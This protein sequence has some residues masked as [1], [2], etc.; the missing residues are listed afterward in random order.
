VL[1]QANPGRLRPLTAILM[2]LACASLLACAGAPKQPELDPAKVQQFQ[3]RG[4]PARHQYEVTEASDLR[5]VH[6]QVMRLVWLRPQVP[7]PHPLVVYMPGAGQDA[8]A[9]A[10]WRQALAEA[11]YVVLSWQPLPDD[12]RL[13]YTP[14]EQRGDLKPWASQRFASDLMQ[15]RAQLLGQLMAEL[16]KA[17]ASGDVLLKGV[18]LAHVA[19]AG[20]ELG[21]Y[22]TMLMAGEQLPGVNDV[23]QVSFQAYVVIS[24]FA[25]FEQG[26]F[27]TRY[28]DVKGPMLTITSEAD[29]DPFKMVAA[30]YLRTAPFGGMPA[31]DKVMLMMHQ[32]DHGSLGGREGLDAIMADEGEGPPGGAGP[33]KGS[34]GRSGGGSPGGGMPSGGGPGGGMGGGQGGPGGGPGGDSGAGGG[35]KAGAGVSPTMRAMQQVALGVSSVAFLDAYL[36]AD[37]LARNWMGAQAIKW[38]TP[39]ADWLNK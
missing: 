18:D 14:G 39:V 19:L 36:Q 28:K 35:M 38:L 33:G 2:A 22:T 32:A 37:P 23:P 7:G 20:Y 15:R 25:S 10:S 34:G 6:G 11:G 8:K 1:R 24:P 26:R 3:S 31:G 13:P 17:Q 5:V 4:Y 29:T 16:P 12:D 9:F 30:A 27:D 21:A